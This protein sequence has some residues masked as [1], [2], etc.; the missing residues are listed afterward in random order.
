MTISIA[1][2]TRPKLNQTVSLPVAIEGK[3]P[4]HEDGSDRILQ[5]FALKNV[6]PDPIALT[7][8]T[9]T[10]NDGVVNLAQANT[11]LRVGDAVTGTGIAASSHIASIQSN[12]QFTL[13]NTPEQAGSNSSLTVTPPTFDATLMIVAT[14]F[15]GTSSQL[16]PSQEYYVFDGS[17]AFDANRNGDDEATINV[18]SA[19]PLTSPPSSID[20]DAFLVKAR[21]AKTNS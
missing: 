18:A 12:T 2:M 7:G 5:R 8:A 6:T 10:T 1:G 15:T 13:N 21:K 17:Q 9:W 19:G 3:N 14:K 20:I 4:V 16:M 11:N